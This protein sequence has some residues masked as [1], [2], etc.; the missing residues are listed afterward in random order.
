MSNAITGTCNTLY[1]SGPALFQ[2][3]TYLKVASEALPMG[4]L[5]L[6]MSQCITALLEPAISNHSPSLSPS[7]SFMSLPYSLS[8]SLLIT[9]PHS[10]MFSPHYPAVFAVLGLRQWNIAFS[11]P[12]LHS[13]SRL[14]EIQCTSQP[15][16]YV[17]FTTST[18]K[19]YT[20]RGFA[21]PVEWNHR[22]TKR[23]HVAS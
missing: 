10:G 17:F 12:I 14:P 23:M 5:C 6:L 16:T 21:S 1:A 20:N 4:R 11:T 7:T 2:P 13:F 22:H 15:R 3:L 8:S 19:K 9:Q 18:W